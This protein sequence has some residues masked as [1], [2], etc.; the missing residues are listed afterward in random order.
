MLNSVIVADTH[1][2]SHKNSPIWVNITIEFFKHIIDFCLRNNINT[3]YHLGDW[4]DN[5]RNINVL[6]L[7]ASF[8]ILTMLKKANIK[9]YIIIGNHDVYYKNDISFHSLDFFKTFENV[10]LI[11]KETIEDDTILMPW[12]F[13]YDFLRNNESRFILGHFEINGFNITKERLFETSTLNP[14]DFKNYS[15][16]I[17]GHFH[18]PSQRENILYV[19]TPYHLTFND[20]NTNRG[21]YTCI[22]NKLSFFEYTNAPKY[23]KINTNEKV[24]PLDIKGNVVK[25]IFDKDYGK[26]ENEQLLNSIQI[27]EPLEITVDFSN[28]SFSVKNDITREMDIKNPK[29]ILLEYINIIENPDNIE[30]RILKRIIEKVEAT[31]DNV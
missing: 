26:E 31:K 12:I 6:S 1:L 9:I 14:E 15:Q 17:S 4:Y 23:V 18:I 16:V 10:S 2:G 7:I 24:N 25:V 13:N 20:V 5:R 29:D 8:N 21:Y 28:I 27:H 3:I 30:K 11:D 22:D 19:G